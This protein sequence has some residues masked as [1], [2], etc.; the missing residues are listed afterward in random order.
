MSKQLAISS[1][2]AIF[3]MS[4]FALLSGT[5]AIHDRSAVSFDRAIANVQAGAV[6]DLPRPAMLHD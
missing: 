2:F 1:A 3:A 5:N 6:I 4:S